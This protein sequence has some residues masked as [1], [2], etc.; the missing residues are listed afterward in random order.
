MKRLIVA[1]LLTSAALANAQTAASAPPASAAKK[2]LVQKLLVLQRPIY[3]NMARELVMRQ[4]VQVGQAAGNALRSLPEDKRESVGKGI[5]ADIRQ[6]IESSTPPVRDRAIALAPTTIAPILEENLS[7]DEL[8]QLIGWL[9]SPAAKKYQ[10]IGG[11]MQQALGQKLID[12]AGRLVTPELKALEKK[13]REALGMPESNAAS[14]KS[15]GTKPAAPAK[16]AS[17]K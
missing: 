17:G 15:P 7:E 9:E 10:Q 12:E 11:E 1:A 13:V 3:E 2:E 16:K 8:K 4:A 6:F 5:D 14:S